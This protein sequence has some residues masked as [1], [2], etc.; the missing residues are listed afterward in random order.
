MNTK[1]IL[2]GA[3]ALWI[4]GFVP[5]AATAQSWVST[6]APSNVWTAVTISADGN[7]LAAIGGGHIYTSPDYG[8]SWVSNS[9]PVMDWVGLASSSDGLRLAAVA[10]KVYTNSGTTWSL[11]FSPGTMGNSQWADTVA[12]SAD[13]TRL[14]VGSSMLLSPAVYLSTN[15]GANWQEVMSSSGGAWTAVASSWDGSRL[16]AARAAGAAGS[17][18]TSA[19][20]GFNWVSNNAP[21]IPWSSLASSASGSN[22]LAVANPMFFSSINTGATWSPVLTQPGTINAA[23]CSSNGTVWFAASSNSA[24]IFSSRNAG[25]TWVTNTSPRAAWS[26]IGVSADGR[27]GVA[28]GADGGLYVLQAPVLALALGTNSV[29]LRW[30]TN[31]GVL[32]L[33][34]EQSTNLAGASWQTV[35]GS[36][37]VAGAEFEVS[38]PATNSAAYFRLGQP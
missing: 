2:G 14:V 35:S 34:L 27:R 31:Y 32:G 4:C 11:A 5:G 20:G 22:L 30:P 16:T 38:V 23:V 36:P 12:S 1:N 37:R 3:A 7:R 15:S 25:V 13:G 9:A 17:I 10:G 24:R 29:A 26:A 28:A 33:Q 21:S 18:Y 19:N 8:A 6:G